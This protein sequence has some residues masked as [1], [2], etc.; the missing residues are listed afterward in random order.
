M[1]KDSSPAVAISMA[2]RAPKLI[3][4]CEY[5]DT[6]AKPPIHPGIHPNRAETTICPNLDPCSFLKKRPFELMFRLSIIIIIITTIPVMSTAARRAS[7][8]ISA[9]SI[10]GLYLL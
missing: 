5:S 6:D 4:P 8:R 1:T 10:F 3:I 7:R 2:T 9:I